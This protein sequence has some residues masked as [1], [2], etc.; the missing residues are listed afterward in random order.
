MWQREP[1]REIAVLGRHKASVETVAFSHDGRELVSA[2]D[3]ETIALWDVPRRRFIANIGTHKPVVLAATFSPDG[4][5]IASGEY[6]KTVRLYTRRRTLWG[7][8]LD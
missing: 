5:Q 6:D 1:L 8:P 4:R 2:S 7:R 3:D